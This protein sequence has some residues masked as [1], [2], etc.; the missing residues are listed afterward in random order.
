[1]KKTEASFNSYEVKIV[2]N[3]TKINTSVFLITSNSIFL[4][5]FVSCTYIVQ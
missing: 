5:S 1:M 4:F 2:L 3:W